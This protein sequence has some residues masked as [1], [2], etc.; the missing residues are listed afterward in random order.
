MAKGAGN[1]SPGWERGRGEGSPLIA[2][3][4]AEP[5]LLLLQ[6]QALIR[7]SAP[8]SPIREKG[9]RR[10]TLRQTLSPPLAPDPILPSL[11]PTEGASRG[12]VWPGRVRCS[13]GKA[14][15]GRT[16][17]RCRRS[18]GP[19]LGRSEPVPGRRDDEGPPDNR[20]RDGAA[21][22]GA[23]STR[24][25]TST[26]ARS[27]RLRRHHRPAH[28]LGYALKSPKTP[29]REPVGGFGAWCHR[30]DPAQRRAPAPLPTGPFQL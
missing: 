17:W 6:G 27:R 10:R 22:D 4:A 13:W 11:S 7:R 23:A 20:A 28:P 18:S 25:S 29:R 1:P 5:V 8:P 21:A 12:V 15:A 24:H 30:L 19:K 16:P 14:V 26:S 3:G 9:R 2:R